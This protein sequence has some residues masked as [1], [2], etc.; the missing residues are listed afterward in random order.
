M[1]LGPERGCRRSLTLRFVGK[2]KQ[3]GFVIA[4]FH[5]TELG[6]EFLTTRCQYHSLAP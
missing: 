1:E 6:A 4:A 3:K 5:V 2:M